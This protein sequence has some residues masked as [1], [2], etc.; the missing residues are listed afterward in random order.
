LAGNTEGND[1]LGDLDTVQIIILKWILKKEDL[2]M[3]I[4]FGSEYSPV[5]N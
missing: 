3:W 4:E 5:V 1:H 2:R